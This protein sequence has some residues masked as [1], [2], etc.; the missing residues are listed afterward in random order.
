MWRCLIRSPE[1]ILVVLIF[2][3]LFFRIST[4]MLGFYLDYAT[5]AR[6]IDSLVP[7]KM[8]HKRRSYSKRG[9]N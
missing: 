1:K 6:D 9:I 2:I 8:T 7:R 5:T 4:K 3:L